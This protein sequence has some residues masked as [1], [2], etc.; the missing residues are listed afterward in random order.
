MASTFGRHVLLSIE[1]TLSYSTM[2]IKLALAF[3]DPVGGA[4]AR[5]EDETAA[6]E[7]IT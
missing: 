3:R 2:S 6:A 1:H 5:W 4:T 7:Q